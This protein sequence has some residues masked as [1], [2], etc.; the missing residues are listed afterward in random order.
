MRRPQGGLVDLMNC[1]Y[2]MKHIPGRQ[3]QAIRKEADTRLE[4]LLLE[5]LASDSIPLDD[6]FWQRFKMKTEQ[7]RQKYA[8]RTRK[9]GR[10]QKKA[11]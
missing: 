8:G 2:S 9:V 6:N 4:S 11:R 5:G 10:T 7:I 1:C 3:N